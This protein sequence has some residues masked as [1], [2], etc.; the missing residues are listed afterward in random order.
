MWTHAR[1]VITGMGAGD[2]TEEPRGSAAMREHGG[3]VARVCMALL[4]DAAAAELA[5]ERIAR[6]AGVAK[7]DDGK[8]A[9]TTLLGIA[10]G[11]CAVQLSK[12]PIRTAGWGEAEARPGAAREPGLARAS[13]GKLK[14][15]E[16]EAVVLHLV[17]GLDAAHV[18]EACGVDLA[19]A[20]AR[21]ARGI[22]QLVQEEKKR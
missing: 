8:D 7:F 22:S 5:L 11:A 15:T 18:A 1:G 21:L 19:T 10:R 9:R 3:L 4:G 16:R 17:G 12:L 6:E 13:L 14:P 2:R 20:R